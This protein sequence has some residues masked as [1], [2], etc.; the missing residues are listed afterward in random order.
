MGIGDD[1]HSCR[2]LRW[3]GTCY[4]QTGGLEEALEKIELSLDK[5]K[6]I[7]NPIDFALGYWF[8]AQIQLCQGYPE[9]AAETFIKAQ[10]IVND[11]PVIKGGWAFLGL[12]QVHFAQANA[13]EIAGNYR[14]ILENDPNLVFRNPYQAVN[15]LSKLE[16]TLDSPED[17]RAY[18]DLFRQE[19]PELIHAQFQQWYLSPGEI[20]LEGDESI[21]HEYFHEWISDGWVWVDPLEDCSFQVDGGLT[22]QAANERN[23][24]HINRSAPRFVRKESIIGD[25][26]LQVKCEQASSERPAIG[27]LLIW[28]NDK[29]WL[30]LEIGA[31]GVDEVIFRGFKDNHDVVF[32][33][34]RLL[35]QKMHLRL[36]KKGY[37]VSAFCSSDEERWFFVGSTNIP[38]E[39]P[40]R[41]G[42]HANGHINRVVYPGAYLN[43][44]A[45][46]FHELMLWNREN[47]VV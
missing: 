14:S 29:N 15:I 31:R 46:R 16:R 25:F 19:H 43:G 24:Y 18:V 4:L 45:I 8:K 34:G 40:I 2:S 6:I 1:K 21:T 9:E 37:Q 20:N 47:L 5:A 30:C 41:P 10:E 44:T 11:I 7:N 42:L 22:I 39:E 28:Q 33:R 27:G 26:S 23:L 36:E 3:L 35:A 17:F 38:S 32:G 13:R 12:G